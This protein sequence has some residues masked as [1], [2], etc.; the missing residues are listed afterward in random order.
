MPKPKRKPKKRQKRRVGLTL[1]ESLKLVHK[2][3]A[4]FV[5]SERLKAERYHRIPMRMPA[6]NGANFKIKIKKKK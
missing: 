5:D 1:H 4:T 6:D 3:D 2:N